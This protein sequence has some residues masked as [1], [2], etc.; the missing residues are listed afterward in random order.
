MER[1]NNKG[2]TLVEVMVSMAAFSVLM[3]VATGLFI[4]MMKTQSLA[5]DY[6][7]A[8]QEGR[9]ATEIISRYLKEATVVSFTSSLTGCIGSSLNLTLER[10]GSTQTFVFEC[11]N[12]ELTLDDRK[13]TSPSITVKEFQISRSA[14]PSFPK[15]IWYKIVLEPKNSTGGKPV[16]YRNYVN[17]RSEL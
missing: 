7:L 10:G 11:D 4:S 17:T 13:I 14:E 16:V 6:L 9:T 15:A 1:L 2:F 12:G 5:K 3:M 8:Q